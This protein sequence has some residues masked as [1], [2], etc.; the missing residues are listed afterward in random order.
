MLKFR[1]FNAV[2]ATYPA[3]RLRKFPLA[4]LSWEPSLSYIQQDDQAASVLFSLRC[5][6]SLCLFAVVGLKLAGAGQQRGCAGPQSEFAV[7]GPCWIWQIRHTF[8][9]KIVTVRPINYTC[10]ACRG[11]STCTCVS[12]ARKRDRGASAVQG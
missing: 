1:M 6:M 2:G 3:L 8:L 7:P 12:H 4:S 5:Q 9:L 11:G 10:G